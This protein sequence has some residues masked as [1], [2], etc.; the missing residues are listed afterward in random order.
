MNSVCVSCGYNVIELKHDITKIQRKQINF[1]N[2]LN[3]AEHKIF[4]I[5]VDAYNN[6]EGDE[7]DKTFEALSNLKKKKVEVNNILI[8]KYKDI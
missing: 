7:F 5:C 1:I 3:Y 8:E 4:C 2:R 6:Y